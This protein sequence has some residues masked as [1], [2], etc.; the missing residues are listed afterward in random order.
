MLHGDF[1]IRFTVQNFG[2]QFLLV[3]LV[4]FMLSKDK[5]LRFV[6]QDT[7]KVFCE[8]HHDVALNFS[9]EIL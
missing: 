5:E 3:Q 1:Q 4:G 6:M 8:R 7:Q 9:W 2:S